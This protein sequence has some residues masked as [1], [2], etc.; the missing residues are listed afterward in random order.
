M[1][2]DT[3]GHLFG[4]TSSG[5]DYGD[6][7]V[8]EL[9][10][11]TNDPFMGYDE[12]IVLA[13]FNGANGAD[14]QGGLI[15]VGGALCGTTYGGGTYGDGTV[16]YL[17]PGLDLINDLYNFQGSDGANP[18]GRLVEDLNGDLLGT[19]EHGGPSGCDT[20]FEEE[21]NG[22]FIA[23]LATFDGSAGT[24]PQGS[25][26]LDSNGNL[27][28]TT[29]SGSA[30]DGSGTIFEV[31]AG[32]SSITTLA[33]FGNGGPSTP[34]GGLVMDSNGNLFGTTLNGGDGTVFELTSGSS[35]ITTLHTFGG[36]D[37]ES[38][39]A[40]LFEDNNGNLY[41]VTAYGGAY[42]GGTVFLVAT[43][44]SNGVVNQAFNQT[45]QGAGGTG[46]LTF[47]ESGTLPPGLTLSS[48]GVISGT[49]TAPG[50]WTFALTVTDATGVSTSLSY[51]INIT[52]S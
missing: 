40:G 11:D 19:T 28:G 2:I 27:Y 13:S 5:G 4:T 52:L 3:N 38:P 43:T 49:P 35:T 41:G 10:T 39:Y 29:S 34:L 26:V 25:L 14:P 51:T 32:S 16:F 24:S 12:F 1:T 17:Q 46:A 45:I 47:S 33:T 23:N 8:F 48:T 21:W 42:G 31:Q 20:V 7:T 22:T 15:D 36:F 50:S 6:G 9:M 18:N 44:P 30:G 37:G